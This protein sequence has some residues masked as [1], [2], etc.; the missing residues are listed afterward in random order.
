MTATKTEQATAYHESGHA[1]AAY[2][3]G[4]HPEWVSIE[5]TADARG[6]AFASGSDARAQA[7]YAFAGP[8]SDKKFWGSTPV[9]EQSAGY[10]GDFDYVEAHLSTIH[11]HLKGSRDRGELLTDPI[12]VEVIGEA[13]DLVRRNWPA[14]N[15]WRTD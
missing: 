15:R 2:V 10:G 9:N 7:T 3:M 13:G 8:L 11:P 5:P 12:V 14:I 4:L 6:M 1:V